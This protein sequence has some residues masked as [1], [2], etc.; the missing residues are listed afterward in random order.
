M[1][2]RDFGLPEFWFL[3]LAAR[4]TIYLTLLSFLLGAVGGLAIAF[5]RTGRQPVLNL[6][7]MGW[8][9]LFQNTPLL[10]QL[11]VIYYGVALFG[12]R[13]S[14]WV[15]GTIG[16]TLHASAYLGEIWRGSI[17]SVPRQQWEAGEALALTAWQMR[18]YVILPQA[19]R[20]SIPPTVG[21]LVQLTKN[22]SLVSLIGIQEL[23]RA[24]SMMNTATWQPFLV[25]LSAAV[26]Y[27]CICFPLTMF[28]R[29]LEKRVNAHH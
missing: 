25:F 12:Y 18:V 22:S 16:L 29:A 8:V 23:M 3:V 26:L 17:Q 11:L 15:A 2:A 6:L 21:F 24:A 20:I 13:P 7:A 5:A 9:R 4:W 27:F 19:F 14:A 28:S 1:G 10:I